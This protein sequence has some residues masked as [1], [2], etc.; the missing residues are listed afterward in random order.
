MLTGPALVLIVNVQWESDVPLLAI[1][2]A[3]LSLLVLWRL[4]S[5]VRALARDNAARVKLEGELSYRAS[6]DPLT[7]LPNRRRFVERLD[8]AL[9]R[10]NRPPLAVLFVDLDDFKTVNDSLG[11]AAGDALLVAVARPPPATCS[12]SDDLAARLGG[13]EFGIILDGAGL[14]WRRAR[15]RPAPRRARRAGR[16]RGPGPAAAGEHRHRRRVGQRRDGRAAAERRRHRDVP[17]EARRQGPRTPLRARL[18]VAR[19]GPAGARVGPP[20]RRSPGTSSSHLPADRRGRDGPRRSSVEALVRWAHPKRGLLAPDDVHPAGRGDRAHRR[21]RRLG[22]LARAAARSPSG[23]PGLRARAR[24]VASTSRRRSSRQPDFVATIAVV[25]SRRGPAAR[26]ADAR[27]HR[28][29]P[30][31]RRVGRP[32]T[33]STGSASSARGSRSTTSAPATRRSA[34]SAGCPRTS[35]RSTARSW[36]SSTTTSSRGVAGRRAAPGR[37]A[38][39]RDDRRGRGDAPTSSTRCGG[40][41]AAS[42]QGYLFAEPLTAERVRGVAPGEPAW[43]AGRRRHRRAARGRRVRSVSAARSSRPPG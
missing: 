40:S 8:G 30:A 38:G 27:G 14:P 33:A 23:A 3:L 5:V 29:R 18:A 17:G 34:T 22:R 28:E 15:R 10:V 6:H 43:S 13:D 11:H 7:G 36:R 42:A 39:P 26:R 2:S 21:H 19:P 24:P 12:R 20:R 41:A 31:R 9:G 1:G 35:S 4:A 32:R 16:D 25:G 37:D